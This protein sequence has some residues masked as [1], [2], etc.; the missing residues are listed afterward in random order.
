MFIYDSQGLI[1]GYECTAEYPEHIRAGVEN[2]MLQW[3]RDLKGQSRRRLG[4]V[5][6]MQG[7]NVNLDRMENE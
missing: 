7:S 6:I 5:G 1:V 2:H 4:K 3:A